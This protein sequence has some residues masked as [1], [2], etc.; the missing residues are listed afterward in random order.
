[1]SRILNAVVRAREG[2]HDVA[3]RAKEFAEE[4][5]LDI[6]LVDVSIQFIGASNLPK[7]D[8]VGLAD[9]Y[10]VAKLDD[11]ITFV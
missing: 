8:I 4:K 2:A 1:M 11:K 6:K 10:F 3:D 7:M 5:M 9:P